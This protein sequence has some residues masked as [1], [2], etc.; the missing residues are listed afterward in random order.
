MTEKRD[1]C[2]FA[3]CGK[4]L[5]ARWQPDEGMKL[6]K[7]H[8]DQFDELVKNGSVDAIWRFYVASQGISGGNN[9]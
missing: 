8:A 9:S 1:K 3:N 5:D 2:E 7:E 4:E 6:C